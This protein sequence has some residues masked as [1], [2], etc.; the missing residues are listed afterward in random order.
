[1]SQVDYIHF[2]S[3]IIWANLIFWGI[4]LILCYNY[5]Q[6][7]YKVLRIRNAIV[8]NL[9]KIIKGKREKSRNLNSLYIKNRVGKQNLYINYWKKD[10]IVKNYMYNII[11][12]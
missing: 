9:K 3:N 6:V 12:Y 11:W 4:Y 5:I 8:K 2:F 1:M 7:I 10:C